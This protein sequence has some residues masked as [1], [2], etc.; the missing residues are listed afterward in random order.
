MKK[1]S[2][3][4][5]SLKIVL[6]TTKS[7]ALSRFVP[8]RHI[9]N[10]VRVVMLFAINYFNQGVPGFSLYR[11]LNLPNW[12]HDFSIVGIKTRTFREGGY[13]LSQKIKE[14]IL[15]NYIEN[16]S[17]IVKA[18][19]GE[20]K[21]PSSLVDLFC[22]DAY[23]SIY[24]LHNDLVE[25]AVGVDSEEGSGEG[26]VRGGVLDQADTISKIC[27]LQGK[28]SL[29]KSDVMEYRGVFDICLCIGGLYH[30]S[31][32]LSLLRRISAQ[33]RH[34]LVIQTIIPS[35][36]NEET[37]F[38]V[39]PAPHWTWG[40]RFNK[41]YLIDALTGMGWT[42]SAVDVKPMLVNSN[43]WDKL[44]LSLLCVKNPDKTVTEFP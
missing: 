5:R 7:K 14:P 23:Y 16:A 20:K 24:A 13:D 26:F 40:S 4:G 9:A 41:K 25:L 22:A 43:E 33:T 19:N 17:G 31:D 21:T 35:H 27:T 11:K 3:L 32:P 36:V 39:T 28:L 12:Y 8:L 6:K 44:S 38:F 37:P 42:I 10:E 30:I 2:D 1:M 18:R 15:F 34:V 29:N